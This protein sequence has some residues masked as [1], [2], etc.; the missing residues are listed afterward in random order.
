MIYSHHFPDGSGQL[1]FRY[2]GKFLP[3]AASLRRVHM[4]L[5]ATL[6]I[7]VNLVTVSIEILAQGR[8]IYITP[9]VSPYT[10][11]RYIIDLINISEHIGSIEDENSLESKSTQDKQ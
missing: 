2:F 6:F 11:Y 7:S 8:N 1:F 5:P 3:S 9:S 4:D 10:Y